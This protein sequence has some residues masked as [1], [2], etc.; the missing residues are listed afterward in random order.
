MATGERLNS[1][2]NPLMTLQVVISIEALRA[3]VTLE[4]TVVRGLLLLRM[5]SI[6]MLH[7][8]GVSTVETRHHPM[9]HSAHQSQLSVRIVDVRQYRSWKRITAKRTLIWK[10]R[11]RWRRLQRRDGALAIRWRHSRHWP[12]C[13]DWALLGRGWPSGIRKRRLLGSC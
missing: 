9:R 6:H 8:S 5:V 10:G 13:A 2:M 3:L 4:R 7:A 11:L 12:S 1:Q